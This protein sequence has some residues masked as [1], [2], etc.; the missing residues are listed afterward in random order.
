M[1]DDL[2]SFVA[3]SLSSPAFAVAPPVRHHDDFLAFS[4]KFPSLV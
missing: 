4:R 1:F 2:P 3:T